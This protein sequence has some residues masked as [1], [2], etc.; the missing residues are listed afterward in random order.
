MAGNAVSFTAPRLDDTAQRLLYKIA[1]YLYVGQGFSSAL[2][3]TGSPVGVVTPA[4]SG[5]LY[6]DNIAGVWY[7][8]TGT[9]TA[10]WQL[11]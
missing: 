4:F 5:Q 11:A 3:G 1:S 9:T 8:S 2:Y 10:S 7:R 6:E